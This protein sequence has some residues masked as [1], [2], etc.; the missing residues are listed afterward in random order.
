[1]GKKRKLSG[2]WPRLRSLAVVS[3]ILLL[4]AGVIFGGSMLRQAF[5]GGDPL[6]AMG[7]ALAKGSIRPEVVVDPGH[8]G[9]DGGAIGVDGSIEKNVNLALSMSLRDVLAV[10]GYDVVMTRETDISLGS[11]GGSIRQQKREDLAAR[12]AIMDEDL[13]RPVIMVHQNTFS[14][15]A[16]SGAQM[17][18]GTVHSDSRNLAESVRKSVVT[19]LQPDNT[20]E[21]KSAPSDVWVLNHTAAPVVMVECGFM[22]N[23]QECALLN[24][25]EYQCQMA[26]AVAYG[27][28][29]WSGTENGKEG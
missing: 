29:G 21:L 8:G 11:E 23:P 22:S 10:F 9:I 16:Y 7:E 27:L 4:V 15:P 20:R 17:F 19:L 5:S 6:A 28:T 24:S 3:I 1:M 12:M 18:Y 2:F 26:F 13:S 14:Q 25:E